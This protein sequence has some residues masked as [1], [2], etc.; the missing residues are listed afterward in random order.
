[1]GKF[2]RCVVAA[3]LVLGSA[4]AS[5]AFHLWQI[6][7]FYSNADGTVQY[8][9]M[10]AL[11]GSQQ[12]L[13]GQSLTST[14]GGP[15]NSFT[16]PSDLPGDTTNKKM[17]IGTAGYAALG[18]VTPDYTVPNNFFFRAGGTINFA[19]GFDIWNHPA[20]PTPPL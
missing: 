17:L 6:T 19:G 10:T 1:M 18:I 3:V 2:F 15:V 12:F 13:N 16:F 9:E 7:E 11:A 20:A 14:A 4:T 5:A 8:I